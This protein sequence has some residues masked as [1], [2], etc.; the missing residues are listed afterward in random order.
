MKLGTKI[1]F[2]A[3]GAVL[4]A[5]II[6]QVVHRSVL[7]RREIELTHQTMRLVITEA[8]QMRQH[9]SE[10]FARGAYDRP[11]LLAE[12]QQGGEL[13]A[14]TLY[15]TIPIVATW[16]AIQRAAE[17]EGFDFR[18]PKHQP[19]N[20]R[21]TPTPAEAEI[22][23]Y[24]ADGSHEE[25]F[26][27][28]TKNKELVY[29]RPIVLT[30]DCLACHGDPKSSPTGDGKDLVGGPMEG[31]KTGETHGAFVLKAK[32]NAVDAVVWAGMFKA[33]F[34]V[35]PGVMLIAGGFFLL[36]R[37]MILG[38]LSQAIDEIQSTSDQTTV[39]A[40]E[41]ASA[42][43]SLAEGA[44]AQAASLEESSASLEEMAT[45]TQRN[46]EHAAQSKDLSQLSRQAA[47]AGLERLEEMRHTL[48]GIK[49]AVAEMT[50]VVREMHGSS[51]EVSKILK[52]IDEIAFQTNLLAL[53]AAVEAARAGEAGMGFAVVADE[54]RNLA[55]RSAAAA[56]D[57]ADK[58]QVSLQRSDQGVAFSEKVVQSLGDVEA[59]AHKVESGF[60]DIVTRINS[61]DTML[62]Q[63]ALASKEQSQGIAHI[64]TAVSQ[65]DH[66][67]QSNAAISEETSSA[68]HEL[69]SQ[70]E[71]VR[72]VSFSLRQM[73]Q[74][75]HAAATEVLPPA[76]PAV[77]EPLI[78]PPQPMV[79]LA[80]GKP[81]TN[82]NGQG[83][84][85][86]P[87]SRGKLAVIGAAAGQGLP[88]ENDFKDF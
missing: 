58:I 21:N 48:D 55:Q 32:F 22:L 42:S 10:L 44:G 47:D 60:Q 57:T 36:N 28:D 63:I 54:V 11:K 72:Q 76:P 30:A 86:G 62:G 83:N 13:Q 26:Q 50:T 7:R 33:I 41:I 67:S 17:K 52:T 49:M 27:V 38:P 9:A 35:L 40:R 77:A 70:A 39:A 64:Q 8:E 87:A 78:L 81:A 75:E 65:L 73:V 61:L 43:Q 15:S 56:K 46:A 69:V 59:T 6:T 29:A 79:N 88:L 37:R 2:A 23:K 84:G 3:V 14:S 24:L 19:R 1:I 66:V 34:W 68:A 18:I 80:R 51:Q 20:P 74:G 25:Y 85:R 82:G 4:L 12:F 45:M 31:W 5:V 71:M 53:N 16:T